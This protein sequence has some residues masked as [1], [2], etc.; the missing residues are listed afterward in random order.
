MMQKKSHKPRNDHRRSHCQE[1]QW[2][3]SRA[4]PFEQPRAH[5]V[6]DGTILMDG[7]GELVG[8][9][10]EGQPFHR[11]LH[12]AQ[13]NPFCKVEL[14]RNPHEPPD[15]LET[16]EASHGDHR[17]EDPLTGFEQSWPLHAGLNAP[18]FE[19]RYG[20]KLTALPVR[21]DSIA[22]SMI[23]FTPTFNSAD[24]GSSTGLLFRMQSRK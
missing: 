8:G 23:S 20:F 9:R 15:I 6:V 21:M 3:K 13:N 11:P 24:T 12:A 2:G 19:M 16:R 22:A 7:H 1:T 14:V 18:L 17:A 10:V 5:I 4:K